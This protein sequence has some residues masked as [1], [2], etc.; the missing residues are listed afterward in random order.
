MIRQM[1]EVFQNF[2][3]FKGLWRQHLI[4]LE[5]PSRKFL[6]DPIPVVISVQP[7]ASSSLELFSVVEG[8]GLTKS[9]GLMS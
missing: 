1:A 4:I 9:K 5:Q 8:M 2:V 6:P 7:E 3:I